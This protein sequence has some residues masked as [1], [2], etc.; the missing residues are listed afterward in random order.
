MLIRYCDDFVVAFQL[1][2]EA[3]AFYRV[4]PKRLGKYNLA[5]SPEKTRLIRFSRFHPGKARCF[6]FLCFEFYWS[7]DRAGKARLHCRT[8]TK[9][10]HQIMNLLYRWIKLNRHQRTT[11]LLPELKRKLVG[12]TNYFGLPDNSRS[13]TRIYRHVVKSLFKWLNRRSQRHSYNWSGLKALLANFTIKP[14]RVWKRS[15]VI[16]DWY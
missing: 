16:V 8:S 7:R 1:R 10:Q 4:L 15:H 6:S 9:K 5:I 13:M 12:I 2:D 3:E 14:L 11:V